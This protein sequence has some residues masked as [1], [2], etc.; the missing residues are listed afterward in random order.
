[1]HLPKHFMLDLEL[2]FRFEGFRPICP[3]GSGWN[4]FLTRQGLVNLGIVSLDMNRYLRETYIGPG[5]YL[6]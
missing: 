3:D 5:G 2:Q 4:C 6:L 1:M